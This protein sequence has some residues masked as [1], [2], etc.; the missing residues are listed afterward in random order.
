M[1][2]TSSIRHLPYGQ[3]DFATIRKENR[4]YVDKT[5]FIPALEV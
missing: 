2:P 5:M 4:Y 3:S 1:G